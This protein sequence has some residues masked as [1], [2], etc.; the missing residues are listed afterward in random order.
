MKFYLLSLIF[1]L[2]VSVSAQIHFEIGYLVDENGIRKDVLIQNKDWRINPSIIY[3]KNSKDGPTHTAG[4]NDIDEFGIGD[5][6]R[7]KKFL[8]PIEKSPVRVELLSTNPEPEYEHEWVFLNTLVEGKVNLYLYRSGGIDNF[9]FWKDGKLEP[10]VHKSYLDGKDINQNNQF[11]AQL[12]N[13]LNCGN[14]PAKDFRR[15]NYSAA[16]LINHFAEYNQCAQNEY[17]IFQKSRRRMKVNLNAKAGMDFSEISIEKGYDAGGSKFQPANSLRVGA[18]LELVLPFKRNKWAVLMESTYR[19]LNLE[20]EYISRTNTQTT[21]TYLTLEHKYL[22]TS[23]G[24]RHYFYLNTDFIFFLN[25][26]VSFDIPLKTDIKFDRDERYPMDPELNAVGVNAYPALGVG[27]NLWK[28][29]S[30][31]FRYEME[32]EIKGR[33]FVPTHYDLDWSSKTSSFSILL[34]YQI[35]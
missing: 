28:S 8:A 14:K 19:N 24:F 29:F 21:P 33:N 34:A 31:E 10:L 7:Y 27:F 18:E 22:T 5:E 25:A 35:F 26:V 17:K 30:A 6:L 20:E 11:R 1:F 9:F 3:Y 23:G 16:D 32:R 2:T 4:I 12:Y 13:E 15:I